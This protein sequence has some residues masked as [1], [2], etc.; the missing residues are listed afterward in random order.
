MRKHGTRRRRRRLLPILLPVLIGWLLWS[1]F[2]LKTV[3]VEV[4]LRD[5]PERFD[6]FRILHISD[7][8]GRKLLYPQLLAAAREARADL[9]AIT[10]DLADEESEL[11]ELEVLLAELTKLARVCYVTG[12]H[13]WAGLETEAWLDRLE[14]L[15]VTVLRGS[16]LQLERA[17]DRL[18]IVGADDPNG[19][20]EQPGPGDAL[21][22]VP[23]GEESCTVCLFHRPEAFPDLALQ[24]C[25]LLLSGHNHGGLV[26]LPLLGGIFSPGGGLLPAY[27]GGL[28]ALGD[29]YMLVSRGM[30]GAFGLPRV[31]NPPELPLIILRDRE[32]ST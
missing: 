24:G 28:Y 21:A 7:L 1:N 17:S 32:E 15:G 8:H 27:D 18:Y 22:L 16:F 30:S 4:P 25:D 26:R 12:N 5:L 9:I 6:G 19:Y 14:R 20:R 23:A 11:P 29:S 31:G 3:T 13:E 2:C 10:G